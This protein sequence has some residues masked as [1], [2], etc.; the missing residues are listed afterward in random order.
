MRYSAADTVWI[1]ALWHEVM[2]RGH[3]SVIIYK[4]AW[5]SAAYTIYRHV[6]LYFTI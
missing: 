2:L 5:L 1:A 4:N 3:S 6:K